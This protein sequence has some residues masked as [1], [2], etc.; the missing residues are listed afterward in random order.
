MSIKKFLSLLLCA[1]ILLSSVD[2]EARGGGGRGG[3]GMRGGGS[4]GGG[5]RGGG[6]RGG[7]SGRSTGRGG[8]A[9]RGGNRGGNRGANRGRG[10][11]GRGG[12]G[13]GGYGRYGGRGY[14]YGRGGYGWGGW[15]WGLGA[16]MLLTAGTFA[17][18]SSANYGNPTTVNNIYEGNL[19]QEDGSWS[20]DQQFKNYIDKC[21]AGCKAENPDL[22]R[23]QCAR[24]CVNNLLD[25]QKKSE[26]SNS[27]I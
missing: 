2:L 10:G 15:G 1:T 12:Y 18:L 13:R 20:F 19:P 17:L 22:T 26:A 24:L 5:M 21:A 7:G 4:R 23:E 11:Y 3:G 8:G 9:N 6:M 27:G 16:G 14:G 25:Q